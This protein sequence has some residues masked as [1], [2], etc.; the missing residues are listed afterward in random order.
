MF[1]QRL[2]TAVFSKKRVVEAL[3][4]KSSKLYFV[5]IKDFGA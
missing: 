1:L 4:N 5:R 3:I 2:I